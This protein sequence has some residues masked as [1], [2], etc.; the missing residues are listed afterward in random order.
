[1][2]Q[3]KRYST[4]WYKPVR[5][6]KSPQRAMQKRSGRSEAADGAG[7]LHYIHYIRYLVYVMA[8]VIIV[9]S[10]WVRVGKYTG[11]GDGGDRGTAVAGGRATLTGRTARGGPAAHG[12][13]THTSRDRLP[14]ASSCT[15]A[16][17]HNAVTTARRRWR[18]RRR[19]RCAYASAHRIITYNKGQRM[20][21]Q[22]C[23][24]AKGHCSNFFFLIVH[25]S[26]PCV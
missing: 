16:F 15:R 22:L 20:G 13:V 10:T 7:S 24:W 1:M 21:R 23:L 4:T 26:R 14:V 17:L 11:G 9:I 6:T 3:C 8:I 12:N 5:S 18:R 19:R 25:I 2:D